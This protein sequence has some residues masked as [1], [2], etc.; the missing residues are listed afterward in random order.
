[1][2]P[3]RS[4]FPNYSKSCKNGLRM[5]KFLSK[6]FYFYSHPCYF[7]AGTNQFSNPFYKYPLQCAV[8]LFCPPSYRTSK[9]FSQR[10]GAR[11][12]Y[13][14]VLHYCEGELNGKSSASGDICHLSLSAYY[15][16]TAL[17]RRGSPGSWQ[18]QTPEWG[19]TQ[20]KCHCSWVMP[21]SS[22][23]FQ[24]VRKAD[25]GLTGCYTRKP[26]AV[27]ENEVPFNQQ[28]SHQTSFHFA[29][30]SI[31]HS[32]AVCMSLEQGREVYLLKTLNYR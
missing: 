22:H 3:A 1:M 12:Q 2:V 23:L 19:I 16:C 9:K 32:Y 18:E 20:S 29:D 26:L 17:K 6:G 24:H 13:F 7:M 15:R 5:Q 11:M 27:I 4:S 10:P 25:T 8:I 14:L 31:P 30:G 21:P 28:D